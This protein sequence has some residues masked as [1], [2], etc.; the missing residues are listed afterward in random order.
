MTRIFR[1]S[2]ISA[3]WL[4]PSLFFFRIPMCPFVRHFLAPV[5][6]PRHILVS[7]GVV[8][9]RLSFRHP[10]SPHATGRM[11]EHKCRWKRRILTQGFSIDFESSHCMNKMTEEMFPE[12]IVTFLFFAFHRSPPWAATTFFMNLPL[13]QLLHIFLKTDTIK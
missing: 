5:D 9:S 10:A 7:S 13:L 1:E 8:P 11:T 4:G 6:I 3:S 2:I 12:T